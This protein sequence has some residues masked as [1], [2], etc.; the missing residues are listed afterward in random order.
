METWRA[1]PFHRMRL[2]EEPLDRVLGYGQDPRLGDA[3]R[4]RDIG[5]GLWRIGAER[6]AG[7][8]AWP[9]DRPH[10]SR[11]FSARLHAF[12]WLVDLAAVGPSAHRRIAE[13]IDQWVEHYGEWDE[14]AWDLE[15][16]AERLF[17]WLAHGRHGFEQGDPEI[18]PRLMRSA[19][20][21]AR[22]LMLAQHE[23]N[24][25]P[26]AAF[27]VG[28]AL[29]LASAAGFP[30][31]DGL[32][33][34]GEEILLEACAKQI[35]PDGGHRTRCPEM[36]AEALYDLQTASDALKQ[37]DE[38]PPTLRETMVKM[39]NMLRLVRMGDGGLA[40][41]HG[42]SEGSAAS[43][44]NVLEKIGGD[45]RA[46]Q[47]STHFA[48]Q[49]LEASDLRILFDVG[50]APP[51]AFSERAHASA[52]AFEFSSGPER[53]IVN[54]GAARDLEPAGRMAART[55]NAHSTLIVGDEMSAELENRSRGPARL[56]GPNLDDVR[57]SSDEAGITLQGRHDGYKGEFGL[58]HR[59][60]IFVDHEGKNLRGI[61][62]LIRPV[63]LKTTPSKTPIPFTLRFHLHP[64]VRARRVDGVTIMLETPGAGQ[65]WRFRT[66]APGVDLAASIYWGGR[67]V[68]QET[69]QIVLTGHADPMGHGLAPPNRVR[70]A[71]ARVE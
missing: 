29:I 11:H 37:R 30:D 6:I 54:V 1:N 5:R 58:F 43:I 19:A 71:L 33:E 3:A 55:T 61:D 8:Y 56:T 50:G 17:A 27:K 4:G 45:A 18:R 14:L 25:R 23:L 7:D 13:L 62:E 41:F 22:L 40:C 34:Q 67:V 70:W 53:L 69:T 49:R 21:Q 60:Y 68:P 26:Q 51:L 35:L 20:R 59:R 44:D 32:R 28:A 15:L 38:P 48:F 42:G 46:I 64:S 16:T 12:T 66:D 2:G 31:P 47:Y 65:R 9:W 10:P 39:A 24:E 57:R 63:K 36:L 52:L